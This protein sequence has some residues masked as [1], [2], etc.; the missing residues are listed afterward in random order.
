[1]R[2]ITIN[3]T[4]QTPKH[5]LKKIE[6]QAMNFTHLHVHSHYSLLDGMAKIKEIVDQCVATGMNSVAITDHGN[7]YG[8][9]ELLDYCKKINAKR[10]TPFKPIVGVEAYCARRG[11]HSMST[12]EEI[13]PEGRKRILDRGGWHLILLAKNKVGYHNLCRLVS[14]SNQEDAFYFV[15]RIDR[16]LLER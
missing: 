2:H 9:K 4:S 6:M 1:M 10:E 14:E 5:R 7:M 11:R 12:E 16:E 3:N 15:P 8:I 13:T